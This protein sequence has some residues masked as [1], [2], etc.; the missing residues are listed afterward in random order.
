MV[1][2]EFGMVNLELCKKATLVSS[3]GSSLINH[4][5]VFFAKQLL[6]IGNGQNGS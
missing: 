5:F 1:N 3:L 2:L 4:K 6:K